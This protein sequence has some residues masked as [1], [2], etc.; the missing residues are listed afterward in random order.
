MAYAQRS[1]VHS[2]PPIGHRDG[3]STKQQA[4]NDNSV[5]DFVRRRA[6]QITASEPNLV[7]RTDGIERFI[8]N[9]GLNVTGSNRESS[10]GFANSGIQRQLDRA[11]RPN[12]GD[13]GD[14]NSDDSD[15]TAP[16]SN[17]QRGLFGTVITSQ[18]DVWVEGKWLK[19]DAESAPRTLGLFFIG[20]DYRVDESL[21]FGVLAQFDRTNENNGP[22]GSG[23]DSSGWMVGPYLVAR[24]NEDLVFDARVS[25]GQSDGDFATGAAFNTERW[26][27]RGQFSG[28]FK[29][30]RVYLAPLARV[31][32]YE[33][34]AQQSARGVGTQD[35]SLGRLTFGP[36]F[37][38][39]HKAADTSLITPF[40]TL[41]GIW[42]FASSDGVKAPDGRAVARD[43]FRGRLEAGASFKTRGRVSISGEGF[44]DG[45]GTNDFKAYG[46]SARVIVP[47]Q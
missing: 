12:S 20:A 6:D 3:L 39:S 30:G 40:I 4:N 27:A 33:E 13:T 29:L 28:D 43:E 10:T 31:L 15:A 16:A 45:I 24:L 2:G 32:Y 9:T 44:Y 38:L 7:G 21:A 26:L 41:N 34:R 46:G 1:S 11:R 8:P 17:G 14:R 5:A 35:V 42:D 36:K 18:F 22:A 23:V 37:Y 47:L 25:W 19:I